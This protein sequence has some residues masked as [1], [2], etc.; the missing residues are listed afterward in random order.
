MEERGPRE[1]SCVLLHGQFKSNLV[2]VVGSSQHL[3]G[4][5]R[6][7]SVSSRQAYSID[8][9]PGQPGLH[10]ETLSQKSKGDFCSLAT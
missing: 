2:Q 4:R 10:R 7:I 1:I 5:G 8:R 9:V 3:E 6:Q